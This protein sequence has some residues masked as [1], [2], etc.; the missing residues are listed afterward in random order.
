MVSSNFQ[1]ES[2]IRTLESWGLTDV[3]LPFLLIFTLVFAILQKTRILGQDKKNFNVVI[4]LV[5]ALTVVI[6]HISNNY[7]INYDPV[8]IING[9]LP[10]ISLILV[11]VLML[12]ILVGIWGAEAS[13]AGGSPSAFIALIA[14]IA[15]LWIFGASAGWWNGWSW[16]IRFFGSDAVSLIIIILVFGIIIW[17][18]TKSD[19]KTTGDSFVEKLGDMFKSKKN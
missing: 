18:I 6:P 2:F 1:L 19:S 14:A 3:L 10:G 8:D 15:V 4:A 7:P 16:F 5:M 17:F 13:W 12:F 9:F 11:A